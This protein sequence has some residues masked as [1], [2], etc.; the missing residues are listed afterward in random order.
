MRERTGISGW[1]T[2]A[3][4]AIVYDCLVMKKGKESLSGAVWSSSGHPLFGPAVA[5]IWAAL[6][7]HLFIDKP[8]IKGVRI[9]Q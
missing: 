9:W 5:G 1:L 4:F 3:A 6:T 7:Y 8:T 2:I